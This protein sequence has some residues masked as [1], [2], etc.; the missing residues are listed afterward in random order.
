MSGGLYCCWG[1]VYLG[2]DRCGGDRLGGFEGTLV[3]SRGPSS[4]KN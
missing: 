1:V 4:S 2:G 3:L